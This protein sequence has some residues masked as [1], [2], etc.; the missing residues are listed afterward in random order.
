MSTAQSSESSTVPFTSD[1]SL[2]SETALFVESQ[3]PS[4]FEVEA[5]DGKASATNCSSGISARASRLLDHNET[6]VCIDTEHLTARRP[7]VRSNLVNND[8]SYHQQ[9][10]SI[11]ADVY[12]DSGWPQQQL[13]GTY[14]YNNPQTLTSEHHLHHHHHHHQQQH[15]NQQVSQAE[16]HKVNQTVNLS[17]KQSSKEATQTCSRAVL[18]AEQQRML[19][20]SSPCSLTYKGRRLYH[21]APKPTFFTSTHF[22]NIIQST[23]HY[24]SVP[25]TTLKVVIG[26][27]SRST[28]TTTTTSSNSMTAVKFDSTEQCIVFIDRQN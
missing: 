20:G 10:D 11:G 14:S 22:G 28:A 9:P 26:E 8:V 6:A 23:Q 17:D 2:E 12:P 27:R 1:A 5:M 18:T 13:V 24:Q 25:K 16:W 19:A 4:A 21:I 15:P 7:S 3:C